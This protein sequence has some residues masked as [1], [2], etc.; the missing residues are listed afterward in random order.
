MSSDKGTTGVSFLTSSF[1]LL[2]G[3]RSASNHR[4]GEWV[5]T[6]EF[7]FIGSRGRLFSLSQAT[8][9]SWNGLGWRS[10]DGPLECSL[11]ARLWGMEWMGLSR[12]KGRSGR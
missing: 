2:N 6:G 3:L 5:V 1:F 4:Y 10:G 8:W 11:L 7:R 9:W 12:T